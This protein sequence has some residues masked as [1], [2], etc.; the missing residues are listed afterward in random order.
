MR[1]KR[2]RLFSSILITGAAV[3]LILLGCRNPL[4]NEIEQTVLV[5]VTPPVITSAYPDDGAIDI[6]LN[7]QVTL[8]FSKPVDSSTVTSTNLPVAEEGDDLGLEVAHG[9]SPSISA[10]SSSA[11]KCWLRAA[12][13]G[14]A[15]A[16]LPQPRHSTALT[17]HACSSSSKRIAP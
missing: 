5:A 15:A 14:Q 6:P 3:L 9:S 11:V 16:Q 12:P 7:A 4:L 17:S 1:A 13:D 8:T 10:N 2:N